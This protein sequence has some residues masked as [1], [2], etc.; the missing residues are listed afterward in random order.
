MI[1]INELLGYHCV[2]NFYN[3]CDTK[4]QIETR[5]FKNALSKLIIAFI[6]GNGF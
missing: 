2:N 6:T 4:E 1:K 3:P 5:R